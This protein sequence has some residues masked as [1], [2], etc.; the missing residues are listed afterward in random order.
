MADILVGLDKMIWKSCKEFEEEDMI[1]QAREA[2]RGMIV[3]LGL[4]FDATPKDVSSILSPPLEILLEIREKLR[5]AKQ[6][7]LADE[8]RDRLLQI[9]IIVEDTPQGVRWHLAEERKEHRA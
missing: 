2:L 7:K 9:G 6:W 3:Q 5:L 1:S 8:I 4:R